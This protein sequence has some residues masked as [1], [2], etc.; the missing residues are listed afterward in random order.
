MAVRQLGE[1]NPLRC[2]H[3][4]LCSELFDA[5]DQDCH[6]FDSTSSPASP[7]D[8][9]TSF[10][11][12]SEAE[13][14]FQ[15]HTTSMSYASHL[16]ANNSSSPCSQQPSE[17]SISPLTAAVLAGWESKA[18]LMRYDVG[19]CP[20]RVLPGSMGF[21]AQLNEGRANKKRATEV[22]VDKVCQPWDNNKF[23]FTKALVGEALV[24]FEESCSCGKPEHTQQHHAGSCL[25]SLWAP[26]TALGC[27]SSS[28]TEDFEDNKITGNKAKAG[29]SFCCDCAIPTAESEPL[30]PT[31][32][33]S[34]VSSNLSL[35][36]VNVSPID[37]GHVLLVP[38]IL[39]CQPQLLT[40]DFVLYGLHFARQL[41]HPH[42]RVGYNSLGAFATINHL[43][44]QVRACADARLRN[45]H[46]S[47]TV[48]TCMT[49]APTHVKSTFAH[50][51][52]A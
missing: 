11:D 36:L 19:L 25:R 14:R 40:T 9:R 51:G 23:N 16:F 21:I 1:L 28:D 38:S 33:S 44:F 29:R 27:S 7:D 17:P 49:N 42:M 13:L 10:P 18:D 2:L 52:C 30:S 35:I 34:S 15:P 3:P 5:L 12:L 24:R 6:S 47:A 41:N 26:H 48:H 46:H 37:Y 50:T 4:L 20:T 31:S 39:Q 8:W 32:T 45:A 43:H 22:K